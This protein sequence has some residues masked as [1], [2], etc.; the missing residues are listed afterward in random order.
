[1]AV[2]MG[3]SVRS[4]GGGGNVPTNIP[5]V[6]AQA[7]PNASS[8]STSLTALATV[9]LPVIP[10]NGLLLVFAEWEFTPNSNVKTC[11][12]RINGNDILNPFDENNPSIFGLR[13]NWEIQN[14]NSQTA[15]FTGQ[16]HNEL[17]SA[18]SFTDDG[19]EAL[20][21]NVPSVLTLVGSVANAADSVTLRR[22]TVTLLQP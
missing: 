14:R 9:N 11:G 3:S 16:C 5:L 10:A 12:L 4:G 22:Y 17:S 1:M 8:S 7:A 15:Q 20:A 6:L 21:L 2:R 19:T 13:T 18:A